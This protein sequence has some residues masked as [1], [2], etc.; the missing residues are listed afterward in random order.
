MRIKN[1]WNRLGRNRAEKDPG[2]VGKTVQNLKKKVRE[3]S[4]LGQKGKMPDD[5]Y[6][7]VKSRM[8]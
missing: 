3:S 6:T 8:S 4:V 1:H 7:R 2:G 5:A